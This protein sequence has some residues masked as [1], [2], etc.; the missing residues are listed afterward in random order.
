MQKAIL[1]GNNT[2]GSQKPLI[3]QVTAGVMIC[4]K[5]G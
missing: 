5:G 4:K 3:K 2:T 1:Y